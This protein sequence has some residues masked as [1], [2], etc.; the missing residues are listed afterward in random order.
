MEIQPCPRHRKVADEDRDIGFNSLPAPH[1]RRRFSSE[2]P[3]C[4]LAV[5]SQFEN[6]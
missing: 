1:G 5:V 3:A 4:D 2:P 6:Q